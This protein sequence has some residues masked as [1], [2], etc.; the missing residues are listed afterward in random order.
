[1]VFDVRWGHAALLWSLKCVTYIIAVEYF[2]GRARSDSTLF[3]FGYWL[4]A[5]FQKVAWV[6]W[7]RDMP[8]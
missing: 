7:P 1:M 8:C 4:S 3:H 6:P 2:I 5:M